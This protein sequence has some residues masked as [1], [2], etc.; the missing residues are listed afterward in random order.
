MMAYSKKHPFKRVTFEFE[1]G[2]ILECN[3]GAIRSVEFS[4][5]FGDFAE[6][7]LDISFIVPLA[8]WSQQFGPDALM[9]PNDLALPD[10]ETK[11]DA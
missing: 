2:A 8:E 7:E 6:A 9:A 4:T 11:E 5:V 1:D 3:L 10:P